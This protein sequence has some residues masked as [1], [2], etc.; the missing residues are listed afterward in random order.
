MMKTITLKLNG[1]M[2]SYGNVAYFSTRS[3][4]RFPTKSAVIGLI[5]SA[6]G[7]D[8]ADDKKIRKLNSLKFAVRI[9]MQGKERSD[10]QIMY[11][12]LEKKNKPINRKY[13]A[14][15]LFLIGL[16]GPEDLIDK[17]IWAMA[18]PVYQPFLGRKAY[19]PAGPIIVKK[20]NHDDALQVLKK[21]PWQAPAWFQKKYQKPT[22]PAVI[23]A[24]AELNRQKEPFLLHD[25]LG[26][27]NSDNRYFS[28]R[29]VI[30]ENVTLINDWT[31]KLENKDYFDEV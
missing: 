28:G 21:V 24:D 23:I 6:L 15:A 30:Q 10:Y 1:P 9:D 22:F 7:Y 16:S 25:K 13:L 4:L 11:R 3:T 29:L 20:F 27:F 14:D 26:S 8:R 2:Q 19:L 5:S 18:H 31:S 17:I 12:S